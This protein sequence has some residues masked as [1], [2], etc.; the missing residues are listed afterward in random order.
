MRKKIITT[1]VC[2]IFLTGMYAVKAGSISL[3][4]S[5]GSIGISNKSLMLSNSQ[6]SGMGVNY[7]LGA[8]Q[9]PDAD[10]I[11]LK[12]AGITGIR[13]L[14]FGY[15]NAANQTLAQYVA[16]TSKAYGFYTIYGAGTGGSAGSI[17]ST[18]W[19]NFITALPAV[20]DWAA[21]NNMDECQIGNEEE[22]HVDNTTEPIA[23]AE[24]DLK[25]TATAIKASHPNL[26]V[27]YATASTYISNWNALGRGDIDQLA[28]NVYN[29]STSLTCFAN[30]VGFSID[31]IIAD[32]GVNHAY[33]SE[34]N[35]P[36]G[37]NDFTGYGVNSTA[38]NAFQNQ[39]RLSYMINA[40]IK[41]AFFFT[42]RSTVAGTDEF[43]IIPSAGA[44]NYKMATVLGINP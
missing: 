43:A 6:W 26:T 15:S 12:A 10:F 23:S 9:Q 1:L 39:L 34:W 31:S 20:C 30:T 24:A 19:A 17:D 33:V 5:N 11:K 44:T 32:F 25:T 38:S 3:N 36:N 14:I 29:C 42:Y 40:G 21:A 8:S 41:R 4:A 7:F 18:A 16:T 22:I 37:I 28:W 27:S 35:T 2:A 13:D